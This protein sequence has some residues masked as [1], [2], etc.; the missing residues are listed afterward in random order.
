MAEVQ[1]ERSVYLHK[2]HTYT[3]AFYV[4]YYP[5]IRQCARIHSLSE[6]SCF[7]FPTHRYHRQA[8]SIFTRVYLMLLS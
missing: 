6:R 1:I 2:N 5:Y 7:L 4:L 8:L 3:I